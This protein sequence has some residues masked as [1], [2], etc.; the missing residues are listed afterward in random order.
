MTGMPVFEDKGET[1][2]G[3]DERPFFC[4]EGEKSGQKK[5]LSGLVTGLRGYV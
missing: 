2:G 4:E 5:A 3:R 1:M